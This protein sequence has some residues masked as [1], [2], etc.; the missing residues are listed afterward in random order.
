MKVYHG[1]G[2]DFDGYQRE[3]SLDCARG[4]LDWRFEHLQCRSFQSEL[5]L[6]LFLFFLDQCLLL[7]HHLQAD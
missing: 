3:A 4:I 1:H 2:A 7:M 6:Y 5:G